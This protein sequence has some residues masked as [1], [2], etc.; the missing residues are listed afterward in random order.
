LYRRCPYQANVM[1]TFEMV[2]SESVVSHIG[3]HP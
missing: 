1:K 3:G 2:N